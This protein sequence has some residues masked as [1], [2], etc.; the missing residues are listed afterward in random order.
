M[1]EGEGRKKKA[2]REGF[3]QRWG[4]GGKKKEEKRERSEIEPS[5]G[6]GSGGK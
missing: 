2:M 5:S 6:S 1:K 3:V 4:E